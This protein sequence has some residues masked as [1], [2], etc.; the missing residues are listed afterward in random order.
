MS[1]LLGKCPEEKSSL[2]ELHKCACVPLPEQ[3]K[4]FRINTFSLFSRD[5]PRL[6][7]EEISNAE[8][9]IRKRGAGMRG[10]GLQ[11]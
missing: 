5:W 7:D 9:G 4:L 2:Y 11:I 8:H 1:Q 6:K 10:K 3:S